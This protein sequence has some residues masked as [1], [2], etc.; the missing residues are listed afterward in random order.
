MKVSIVTP[1]Y[2]GVNYLL[3]LH[4]NLKPILSEEIDWIIVNDC[5]TDN[6]N[7]YLK[8][9]EVDSEI[10]VIHLPK[11]SGPSIARKVGAE[12][13]TKENIFFLDVDDI[14]DLERFKEFTEFCKKEKN[15]DFFYAPLKLIDNP[16]VLK[17]DDERSNKIEKVDNPY[18]FIHKGFPQPSSLLVRKDF[19][20]KYDL[21]NDLRWG[22]DFVMYLCLAKYG[23]GLKWD[24]VVS[25]YLVDGSGRGSKLSLKLRFRLSLLLLKIAIKPKKMLSSLIYALFLTLR[26][27]ASYLYKKLHIMSRL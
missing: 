10:T 17:F 26:H 4:D 12:K 5:S 8:K 3:R 15:V 27:I 13:S 21:S 7:E 18:M 6:S 25:F 14:V 9:L 22:E 11:N 2:N 24:K 19:Y 20:L 16:D 1:Y 23:K